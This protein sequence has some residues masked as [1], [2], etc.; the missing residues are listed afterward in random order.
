MGDATDDAVKQMG[1]SLEDSTTVNASDDEASA[2]YARELRE[3]APMVV[4]DAE[5]DSIWWLLFI[6]AVVAALVLG[7]NDYRRRYKNDSSH[8]EHMHS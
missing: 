7:G 1:E 8:G 4:P 2:A 6:A 3:K 5:I